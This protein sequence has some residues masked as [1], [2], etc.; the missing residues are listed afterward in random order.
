MGAGWTA[1]PLKTLFLTDGREKRP[2]G[3]RK[4]NF[5]GTAPNSGLIFFK[6]R[7]SSSCGPGIRRRLRRTHL[8]REKRIGTKPDNPENP[9]NRALPTESP[10]AALVLLKPSS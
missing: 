8:E 6:R 9:D 1:V 7:V 2:S 10:K 3:L 4:A 5:G